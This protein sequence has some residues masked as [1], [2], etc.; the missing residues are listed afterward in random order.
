MWTPVTDYTERF[1]KGFNYK[2]VYHLAEP[3]KFTNEQLD[4]IR[5]Q[6]ESESLDLWIEKFSQSKDLK[7]IEFTAVKKPVLEFATTIKSKIRP[8]QKSVTVTIIILSA[9]LIAVMITATV[10]IKVTKKELYKAFQTVTGE[11]AIFNIRNI[12]SV[13]WIVL[14]AIV[15]IVA[16]P[17]ILGGKKGKK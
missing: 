12:K 8:V 9:S 1:E 2:L 7:T 3:V 14:T 15:V 11:G 5:K 16:F 10:F 13:M 17:L 4:T 6:I